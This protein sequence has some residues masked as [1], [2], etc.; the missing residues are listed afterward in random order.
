MTITRVAQL[1]NRMVTMNVL[2]Q[3]QLIELQQREYILEQLMNE[4]SEALDHA[5]VLLINRVGSDVPKDL[6]VTAVH[7][8]ELMRRFGNLSSAVVS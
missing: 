4:C 2:C 5:L 3:Q 8:L 7:I 1:K 6:L